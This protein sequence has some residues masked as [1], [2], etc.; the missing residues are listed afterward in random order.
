MDLRLKSIIEIDLHMRNTLIGFKN[1]LKDTTI[2]LEE[3]WDSLRKHGDHLD[4]ES[5][6]CHNYGP[7]ELCSIYD[8]PDRYRT[9]M[10]VDDIEFLEDIL[11]MDEHGKSSYYTFNYCARDLEEIGIVYREGIDKTEW[12]AQIKEF[13]D[14]QKEEIL[15]S[16]SS[17]YVY[18][19]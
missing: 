15:S 14:E 1:Y 4:S 10:Y 18:D 13:I 3:R 11:L 16:G 12:N 5:T 9:Y 2:P 17:G 7:I 19:W 8:P 6:S